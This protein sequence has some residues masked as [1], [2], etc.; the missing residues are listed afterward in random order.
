MDFQVNRVEES[1][2][3]TYFNLL[4]LTWKQFST[5]ENTFYHVSYNV[6]TLVHLTLCVYVLL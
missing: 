2:T 3:P 5:Q 4:G 6:C 1:T